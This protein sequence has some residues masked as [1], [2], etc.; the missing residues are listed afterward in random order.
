MGT[1]RAQRLRSLRALPNISWLTADQLNTLADALTVTGHEMRSTI[2][3]DKS[4]SESARILLSGVARITCV[5][6]KGRRTTAIILSPGLIPAF[7]TAVEGITY[8]FRCEAVTSCQVGTIGLNSFIKICL[9][10]GSAAFKRMA[11]SFLG[12][13]DRV[14]LRCSNLMACTL[15]ERLA[16]VLLD[17]IEN[18][19]VP[20]HDGGVRLTVLVRHYDLAELVGATRPRVSE[21]MRDFAQRH[22]IS[23]QN[24]RW[25]L[26][27]EGLK[28]FLKEA[29][30]EELSEELA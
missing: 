24:E 14:H 13:W 26:D 18:F 11:A 25:V 23:L 28:G 10:I 4:T 19:G 8:N 21:H 5:N 29:H 9:G 17:L 1:L 3:S 2:F 15:E 12:R 27:P 16:L 22:L 6:R 7:P 20:N 30:R